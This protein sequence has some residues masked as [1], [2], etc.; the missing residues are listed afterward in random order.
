MPRRLKHQLI[1]LVKI[2]FAIGLIA[3]LVHSGRF[4]FASLTNLLQPSLLIPCLVCI[5]LAFVFANE[6]WRILLQ[7]HELTAHMTFRSLFKLTLIGNFFNFAMPGGIGGDL[8]KAYY[9]TQHNPQAKTFSVVSI[10]VDR[11][12]GL[13]ATIIM[14][15]FAICLYLNKSLEHAELRIALSFL[16]FLFLGFTFFWFFILSEKIHEHSWAQKLIGLF[17]KSKK[18]F[19]VYESCISYRKHKR[20]FFK[21]VVLSLVSQFFTIIFFIFAGRGLGFSEVP[22]IAYF[23]V[24]PLGFML[25]ALPIS[26]AGIGVGQAAFLFLFNMA[27]GTKTQVGPTTITAYQ[28]LLFAYGL[29]GAVFYL[30]MRRRA[31]VQS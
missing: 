10:V 23:F 15:I 11:L 14:A 7:A 29:V 12:A 9:I 21:A 26:V 22:T 25:T 3:W 1:Q 18:L 19:S 24:V 13:Y 31:L 2:T 20:L 17:S 6:R 16:V 5:G 30:A 28:V 8:I 27:L 4:D